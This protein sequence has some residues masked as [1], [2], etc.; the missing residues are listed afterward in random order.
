MDPVLLHGEAEGYVK[1][2]EKLPLKDVGSPR[3]VY[4]DSVTLRLLFLY[5]ST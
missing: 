5:S 2:L 1:S 3:L 4:T